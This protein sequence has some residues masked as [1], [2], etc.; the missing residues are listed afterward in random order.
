M[1]ICHLY[2]FGKVPVKAFGPLKNFPI[3]FRLEA[4]LHKIS[5]IGG[6]QVEKELN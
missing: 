4:K 5:L 6:E 1:L 3:F 2:N